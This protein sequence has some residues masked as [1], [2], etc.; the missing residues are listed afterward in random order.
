MDA[1]WGKRLSAFRKMGEGGEAVVYR[2]LLD[3]T[4]PVVLKW[5]RE[6]P[7]GNGEMA[8]WIGLE[9]PGVDRI[10]GK[11]IL[12]GRPFVVLEYVRGV[13]TALLAPMPPRVAVKMLRQICRTLLAL[14]DAGTFHGDLSPENVLVDGEGNPHLVDGGIGVLGTPRYAAPERFE[15]SEPTEKSEMF[16]LGALLYFW[17]AGEPLFA[18]ESLGLVEN[19]VFQVD[20]YDASMRLCSLGKLPPE[21]LRKFRPLW[22]GTLR[23]FPADRFED[24]D[25]LDESLEIAES[26]LSLDDS[27]ENRAKETAWKNE[28]A[29]RIREWE[30]GIAR[31]PEENPFQNADGESFGV[32]RSKRVARLKKLCA[33]FAVLLAVLF[34]FLYIFFGKT[35]LPDVEQV[36]KTMLE[37]TRSLPVDESAA[38]LSRDTQAVRG[39]LTDADTLADEVR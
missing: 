33:G 21:M 7:S 8:E 29:L 34:F 9:S 26:E 23:R 24:L 1:D 32:N 10:L 16:S 18:G 39:I 19:A 3:G 4:H 13:S 27:S 35:S 5:A 12:N 36:G 2:A 37:N 20:S 38:S 28:L 25:E 14:S 22:K 17:I 30:A 15:G 31:H 6:S 11:G